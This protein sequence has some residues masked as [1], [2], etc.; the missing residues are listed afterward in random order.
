MTLSRMLQI[1]ENR[2]NCREFEHFNL[3]LSYRLILFY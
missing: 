1:F 2:E 3:S